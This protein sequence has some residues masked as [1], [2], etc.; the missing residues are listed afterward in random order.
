MKFKI[1]DKVKLIKPEEG[2]EFQKDEIFTIQS[3]EH[4]IDRDILCSSKSS[5]DA[6]RQWIQ[7]SNLKFFKSEIHFF[8]QLK[9]WFEKYGDQ[10]PMKAGLEMKDLI[11]NNS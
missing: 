11:E 6:Q 1:G 8:D 5:Y 7:V 4:P 10:L 3:E 2:C 9:E